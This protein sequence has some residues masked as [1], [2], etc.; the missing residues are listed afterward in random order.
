[1]LSVV[2]DI[3]LRYYIIDINK[4]S[5]L[6]DIGLLCDNDIDKTICNRKLL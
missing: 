5:R 1:M 2:K 6:A 3:I 4:H